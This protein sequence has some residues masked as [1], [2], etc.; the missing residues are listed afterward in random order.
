MHRST[1]CKECF[2]RADAL[3]ESAGAT[4]IYCLHLLAAIL[5]QPGALITRVCTEV[6]VDI[7]ALRA[8]VEA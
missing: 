4:K 6:G 7:E 5:E 2:Q 8:A 1:A 3:A